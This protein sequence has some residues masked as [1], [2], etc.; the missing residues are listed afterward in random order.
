MCCYTDMAKSMT[1]FRTT[2]QGNYNLFLAKYAMLT[3]SL[4]SLA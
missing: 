1:Q 2:L 3:A 4:V